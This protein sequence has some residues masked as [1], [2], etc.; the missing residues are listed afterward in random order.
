MLVETVA[1]ERDVRDVYRAFADITYWKQVL[2]DVLGVELLYDDG[3]H[4]EFTMTVSR[5]SGAETVRGI[6]FCEGDRRIELVQPQPPPSFRRMV[7]VWTFE[8]EGNATRVK[9]ERWFELK[10]ASV[11]PLEGFRDRIAT[12]LRTNLAHFKSHLEA[13]R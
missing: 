4:Q 2:P 5:P 7:G 12:Y 3:R 10:D 9:A 6:R 1:I 8:A 13:A 11:G